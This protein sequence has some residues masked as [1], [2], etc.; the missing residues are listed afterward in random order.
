M[1]KTTSLLNHGARNNLISHV[2]VSVP[3]IYVKIIVMNDIFG[4]FPDL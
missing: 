4:I 1:G 2:S 3:D